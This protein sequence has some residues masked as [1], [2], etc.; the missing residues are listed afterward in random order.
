VSQPI[1][2]RVIGT[3]LLDPGEWFLM[4]PFLATPGALRWVRLWLFAGG[5]PIRD[6]AAEAED[7]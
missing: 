5:W 1:G 2:I 7:G 3:K 6:C 4:S